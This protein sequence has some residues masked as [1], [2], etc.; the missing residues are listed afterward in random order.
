MVGDPPVAAAE[1]QDLD[2]LVEDEPVGDAGAMTAERVGNWR[3]G[4]SAET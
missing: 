4:S 3:V 1:H 2:E